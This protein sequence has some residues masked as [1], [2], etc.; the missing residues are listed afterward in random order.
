MHKKRI[1]IVDDHAFLRI[2]MRMLLETRAPWDDGIETIAEAADGWQG[3]RLV[4]D[5]GFDLVL[6]DL[7]LPGI[8]GYDL[9]ARIGRMETRP[10][11]LV[12]SAANGALPVRRALAAGADG[13]VYKSQDPGELL[14]GMAAVLDGYCFVPRDA[15]QGLGPLGM[16][17]A[18]LS[19][20]ERCVAQG[21]AEG[22]S[23]KAI[24]HALALSAKTVSAHKRSI[25]RK[26]AVRNLIELVDR[27][28]E[29]EPRA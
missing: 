22:Q 3:W 21:L 1:A 6:L 5:G 11:V 28:R 4:R 23:N 18:A 12:M 7:H 19:P 10:K 16:P 13:F 9:L 17:G 26:L 20:R 25:F 29:S 2:G 15:V 8:D 24:A 27:L 14:R